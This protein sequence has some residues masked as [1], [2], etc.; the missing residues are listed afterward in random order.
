MFIQKQNYS[1]L[2]VSLHK[3]VIKMK[4]IRNYCLKEHNTFKIDVLADRFIS[5]DDSSEFIQFAQGNNALFNH[6]FLITGEGSNLLFTKDFNGTIIHPETKAIGVVRE[7]SDY[8]YIK[9][10][11]GINWDDFVADTI[12]RGGFG[13]E[14]L[15][16]IPG[17]VGASVVQNIGAYGAE[18]A[19]FVDSVD[20]F[21]L[22]DFKVKTISKN[23]CDFAYR[24][25]IFKNEL[26]GKAIVLS[27]VYRL[28]KNAVC[29]T[30]YADIQNYFKAGEELN[31]SKIRKAVIDI[32]ENKLPDHK[33][34][35]NAGSFFKNPIIE[36]QQFV[37]LIKKCPDLRYYELP[38][39]RYKL[40]AGWMIDQCNLKGYE[41]KGAAIHENQALVLINKSGKTTGDEVSELA[42]I[43]HAK[44]FQKYGVEL[45]PEVIIL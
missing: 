30:S 7:S 43:V 15:S 29:N 20:Y 5:F 14:N 41:H 12:S 35:G 45:E 36:K 40:A 28:S 22:S 8:I 18:A 6:K 23:D 31:P 34:I 17:T 10:E 32:R 37:E 27:V 9:A 21:C 1:K 2:Y 42:E 39:D 25:S 16:L 4:D 11:A 33:K 3:T 26:K 38:D 44:V 13:L 24:N 19:D